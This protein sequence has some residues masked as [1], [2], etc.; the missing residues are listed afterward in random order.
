MGTELKV[1]EAHSR[2]LWER[3]ESLQ[4]TAGLA[5]DQASS[6]AP[7]TQETTKADECASTGRADLRPW[8]RILG[9]DSAR[10]ARRLAW[11]GIDPERAAAALASAPVQTSPIVSS[12]TFASQTP[13]SADLA[14]YVRAAEREN[15]EALLEGA[16]DRLGPSTE[17]ISF[18]PLWLPWCAMARERLEAWLDTEPKARAA[19]SVSALADLERQLLA[20]IAELAEVAVYELFVAGRE[21]SRNDVVGKNSSIDSGH[22]YHRFVDQILADPLANFYS[23]YPVLARQTC[24]VLSQWTSRSVELL[25]AIVRDRHD[26]TVTFDSGRDPGRVVALVGGLSDRHRGGRQ[27]YR[28]T[29]ES[30]LEVAYKPRDLRVESALADFLTW[31]RQAGL[32][33]APPAAAVLGRS[34]YGWMQWIRPTNFTQHSECCDYYRRAGVLAAFGWLL[35]GRDLH[36]ENIVASVAGPVIIDGEMLL[37]PTRLRWTTGDGGSRETQPDSCLASGLLTQLLPGGGE[38][39]SLGGLRNSSRR[40]LRRVRRGVNRDSMELELQV[41]HQPAMPNCPRLDD[42]LALP[43]DFVEE[44]VEGFAEGYR[45]F[46]SH[47]DI[48]LAEDGPLSKFD[49]CQVR[50]LLRASQDYGRVLERMALPR[51]Q[52]SG[53]S[54]SWLIEALHAPLTEDVERPE[55]WPLAVEERMALQEGDVPWFSLGVDDV[56][57][58]LASGAESVG[59]VFA[60]S[61]RQAV[62]EQLL[63]ASEADLDRQRRLVRRCLAPAIPSVRTELSIPRSERRY[64]VAAD[65][66]AQRLSRE[67]SDSS[68]RA[69]DLGSGDVGI[70]TFLSAFV[71]CREPSSLRDRIEEVLEQRATSLSRRLSVDDFGVGSS[72]KL[73]SV[74][75]GV[76]MLSRSASN[77]G[78][79]SLVGERL[80]RRLVDDPQTAPP[81]FDLES[82]VSGNILGLLAW[83]EASSNGDALEAAKRWGD[84]LLNQQVQ[85]GP[86]A[87]GWLNPA[88]LAPY[89]WAHGASGAARALGALYHAVKQERYL[90]GATAAVRFEL[91]NFN[92]QRGNWPFVLT[93]G[94]GRRT[95]EQWMVS[96]C[97]GGPG[98]I[99]SRL[100]LQ[101]E[102]TTVLDAAE[103]EALAV[104]TEAALDVTGDSALRDVDHLCCGNFGRSAVLLAAAEAS[105]DQASA[106]RRRR[107][108][109]DLADAILDRAVSE[110][111]WR[112][113]RGLYDL[114]HDDLGLHKGISG[115]G[116][117]LLRLAGHPILDVVSLELPSEHDRRLG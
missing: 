43:E 40:G 39:R 50:V 66:I 34:G 70:A 24:R 37:Q 81:S 60:L 88:G 117:Q 53:L 105:R 11:E 35:R 78:P 28:V 8:R 111:G 1:I 18:A 57:I 52:R 112:L 48:L 109:C 75:W 84:A 54:A 115:I 15:C 4:G 91:R 23:R 63:L 61:G 59:G 103:R 95:R 12:E 97:R 47:R 30:G 27:V 114:D 71:D 22:F 100:G 83:A 29:F 2:S 79:W 10:L 41:V 25:A 67:L 13:W 110:S 113:G 32:D 45:F 46:A 72:R 87:G 9:D 85:D 49:S 92:S 17:Q 93:D 7:A 116:L 42:G 101:D 20:E 62:R 26:L 108:A 31:S 82:G 77:A 107:Q 19:L 21:A 51:H 96:W 33:T 99:L 55:T 104:Q 58:P 3:L 36:A 68:S 80:A 74:L 90:E 16:R 64:E 86:N 73:G 76:A 89:G 5:D 6:G 94:S 102:L 38:D 106:N 14:A 56:E 98:V 65:R 44:V 69:L